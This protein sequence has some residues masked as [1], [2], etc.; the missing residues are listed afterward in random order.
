MTNI[1]FQSSVY[2]NMVRLCSE[3][4]FHIE[5]LE[6]LGKIQKHN[7]KYIVKF[8]TYVSEQV[9]KYINAMPDVPRGQ[10]LRQS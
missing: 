2:N 6:L 9:W 4:T 7:F 3:Y 5:Y 8:P 1:I 10:N